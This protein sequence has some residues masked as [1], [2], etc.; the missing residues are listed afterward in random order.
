MVD[1]DECNAH[2]MAMASRQRQRT[3]HFRFQRRTLQSPGERIQPRESA[4]RGDLTPDHDRKPGQMEESGRQHGRQQRLKAAGSM[5]LDLVVDRTTEQQQVHRVE[6]DV[7]REHAKRQQRESAQP[8][9]LAD[10]RAIEHD[11]RPTEQEQ[12]AE[13]VADM[14]PL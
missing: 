11:E 14:A 4:R 13:R 12:Q 5:T 6:R 3:V 1:I 9:E 8:S 10:Q 2:G 7:E